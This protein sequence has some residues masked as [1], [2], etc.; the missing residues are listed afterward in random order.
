LRELI[1]IVSLFVLVKGKT[2]QTI[3]FLA[4]LKYT[5]GNGKLL[6]SNKQ[7]AAMRNSLSDDE[8][9][10][11]DRHVVSLVNSDDEDPPTNRPNR[12]FSPHIIVT[13]NSVLS[14]WKREFERF[15]PE[16]NVVM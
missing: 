14:N 12:S 10:N 8:S 2:V 13:P 4:W 15:C 9:L 16:M 1:V 5:D 11:E 6:T 3:A 7:E